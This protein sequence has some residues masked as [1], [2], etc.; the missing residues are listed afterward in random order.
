M[1]ASTF[2]PH[3]CYTTGFF[4]IS[5]QNYLFRFVCFD[6]KF[7]KRN[8]SFP[9]DDH[10]SNT[11]CPKCKTEMNKVNCKFE[12]PKF[13]NGKDWENAKAS[14]LAGH[15]WRKTGLHEQ[16][17]HLQKLGPKKMKMKINKT[18][19]E[20]YGVTGDIKNPVKPFCKKIKTG[21]VERI[22]SMTK[23]N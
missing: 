5:N 8:N 18:H 22:F 14:W 23:R 16:D 9:W 7:Y 1:P 11:K 12:P 10:Y 3:Y 4:G 20:C 17:W 21:K 2:D 19:E 6:C 13:Q 15:V